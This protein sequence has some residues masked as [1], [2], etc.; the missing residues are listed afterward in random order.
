[1]VSSQAQMQEVLDAMFERKV[2]PGESVIEQGD[3]GVNFYVIERSVCAGAVE[4]CLGSFFVLLMKTVL[5]IYFT[6]PKA[7]II[8][9]T[10]LTS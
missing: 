8:S 9:L 5:K 7:K 3:D 1:M 10:L 2:S 4:K 6:A